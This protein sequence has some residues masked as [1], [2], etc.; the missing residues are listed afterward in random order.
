MAFVIDDKPSDNNTVTSTPLTSGTSTPAPNQ[1]QSQS[2]SQPTPTPS[3][4]QGQQPT[5]PQRPTQPKKQSGSGMFTNIQKY[6]EKNK[7]KAEQMGQSS[8]EA[9]R[10]AS[11]EAKD[12]QNTALTKFQEQAG[13][14]G[15]HETA[16]KVSQLEAYTRD[17]AGFNQDNT[18]Q[19]PV[20]PETTAEQEV[21]NES[22]QN[23]VVDSTASY[24]DK[25][26]PMIN[27]ATFRDI[28]NAK[29]RGP[30]S[31]VETGNI[32]SEL[33]QQARESARAGENVQ[34]QQGRKRF[35][36]DVFTD[37]DK[38]YSSGLA[39]LDE[40]ILGKAGSK[41]GEYLK[42]LTQEGKAIGSEQDILREASRRATDVASGME[43]DVAATREQARGA[44]ADIAKERQDEV[45]K[46]VD[47]VIANWD[48]LPAH[49]REI[50]SNPDG[51]VNLSAIEANILGVRSGEGVY[52]L[53]GSDL[54]AEQGQEGYIDPEAARLISQTESS[55]LQRLQA[56]SN[57]AQTQQKLYD[58][59]GSR[60]GSEY[61]DQAGTQSALDALN[62]QRVRDQ[63]AKAE[64]E[65]RD[66]AGQDVT[67]YGKGQASR[68]NFWG[69]VTKTADQRY[70]NSLQNALKDSYD[71]TSP[72]EQENLSDT[73]LLKQIADYEQANGYQ[74]SDY[75]L[76]SN[77]RSTD[78]DRDIYDLADMRTLEPIGDFGNYL[79]NIVNSPNEFISD[80]LD[81]IGLGGIS[82]ALGFIDGKDVQKL[83][84][85]KADKAAAKDLANKLYSRLDA[86]NIE[87]RIGV[88]DTEETR[89]RYENLKKLMAN[90]DTTNT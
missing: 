18:V 9:I 83:A 78:E 2:Q 42:K 60:F 17:Q 35:L 74:Q 54:F 45:D 76:D 22:A 77:Y 7:P 51:T 37:G 82:D 28:I 29:Y 21:P 31:L 81:V 14:S 16:D 75:N 56:L 5:T 72:I 64:Q 73:S 46:R 69:T 30:R 20:Q 19:Q 88:A 6:V 79:S 24:D 67:G 61:Y 15:L 59:E 86:S 1:E 26:L 44:F 10:R 57:L 63:L 89:Q 4:A 25:S 65:F 53:K 50:F 23:Q 71:F 87:N 66:Y 85:A 58:I 34:S 11:Q 43:R 47:D 41:P 52:N 84:Q 80:T 38:E 33:A 90:I 48:K 8:L 49:F 13:S 27:E 12:A 40:Y 55:N 62:T 39:N 70:T 36:K 32:Y 68:G 3:P